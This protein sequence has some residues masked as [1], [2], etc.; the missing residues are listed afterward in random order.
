MIWTKQQSFF[1]N[2]GP[3]TPHV[4]DMYA[5]HL[6]QAAGGSRDGFTAL[7]KGFTTKAHINQSLSINVSLYSI[8]IVLGALV[9]NSS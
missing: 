7:F 9:L 3:V 4:A 6:T 1:D 8:L 2:H 5:P